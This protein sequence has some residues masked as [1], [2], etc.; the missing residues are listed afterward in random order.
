MTL[1][2]HLSAKV[3][4]VLDLLRLPE[5]QLLYF[6]PLFFLKFCSRHLMPILSSFCF[7][8]LFS[9]LRPLF[10]PCFLSLAVS[11]FLMQPPL[12]LKL[13]CLVFLIRHCSIPVSSRK[14][15]SPPPAVSFFS[16]LY[17]LPNL[18]NP[19]PNGEDE[20]PVLAFTSSHPKEPLRLCF[21]ACMPR[22][23]FFFF[24]NFFFN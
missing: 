4:D 3:L 1:M 16:L 6:L 9:D 12:S 19:H 24:F 18:L 7:L 23:F 13:P 5:T 17:Q 11:P 14:R 22:L 21:A 8:L 20:E 15:Q 10:P 2:R